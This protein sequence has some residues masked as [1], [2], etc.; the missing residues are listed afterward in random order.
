MEVSSSGSICQLA[1]SYLF[2]I[3]LAAERRAVVDNG[4]VFEMHHFVFRLIRGKSVL[5]EMTLELRP[6]VT[7]AHEVHPHNLSW[8]GGGGIEKKRTD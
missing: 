7:S 8:G 4:I 3:F 2:A 1:T 6:H 5:T